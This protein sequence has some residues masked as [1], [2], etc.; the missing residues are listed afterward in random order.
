MIFL[1]VLNTI[2]L[3]YVLVR[4]SG[5]SIEIEFERTFFGHVPYGITVRL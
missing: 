4:L 3:I 1:T 5:Y 2:I